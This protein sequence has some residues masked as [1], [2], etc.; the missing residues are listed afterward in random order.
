MTVAKK[1]SVIGAGAIGAMFGGLIK[2]HQPETEVVLIA[3]GDH[4]RE[5]QQ[6]GIVSLRGSW[7]QRD[8]PITAS[9]DPAAVAGSDLILFTVKT[10][11]TVAT[12]TQFADWIGDAIVVS[13][14][15]GINQHLL[16]PIVREENLL[17]GMTATNMSIDQPGVVTCN[18]SGV[19]VIGPASKR[20]TGAT[21]DLANRTLAAS[22]LPIEISDRILGAQYNKL[23]LNTMGYA[24]VLSATDFLREGILDRD[25][26]NQV[27]LPILDEGLRVLAAANRSIE[28]VG[29]MS[30]VFRFRRML[31]TFNLP[32]FQVLV[33]NVLR[34][35]LRLPSLKY[36]VYQDLMRNRPTEIDY[37]NGEVVR[38]ANEC[39][40]D[41][42]LNAEVV[43]LVHELESVDDVTFF[44]RREI[45]ERFRTVAGC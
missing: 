5:M 2:H 26:R 37:V 23:L 10:Q 20:V 16:A 18:R 3:R 42:P 21:L 39:H 12:A 34:G 14:Q 13:L 7:G 31:R 36:S 38:L 1:V 24:S 40:I 30:D 6:R 19:S 33:R 32:G 41:A 44:S 28:R 43:R 22:Q 25:W 29:G 4:G 9:S 17:V 11:D 45:T 15:N 27:A 8:V 35:P